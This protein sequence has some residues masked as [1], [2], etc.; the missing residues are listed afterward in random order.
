M[1]YAV[2]TFVMG[3]EWNG[4]AGADD[5]LSVEQRLGVTLPTAVRAVYG[6]I[7]SDLRR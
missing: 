2:A 1:A 6:R 7:R 4:L 3:G 5:L